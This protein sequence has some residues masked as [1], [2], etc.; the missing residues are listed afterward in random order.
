MFSRITV[1]MV[2]FIC[3][4]LAVSANSGSVIQWMMALDSLAKGR[5]VWRS[6]ASLC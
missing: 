4:A 6:T 2:A 5:A 1:G 3:V